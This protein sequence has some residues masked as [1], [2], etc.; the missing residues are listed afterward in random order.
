[1]HIMAAAGPSTALKVLALAAAL[2]LGPA[3]QAADDWIES[4][5]PDFVEA[6]EGLAKGRVQIESGYAVERNKQGDER[7]RTSSTPLMLRYGLSDRF[8]LRMETEG[9][10]RQRT[11]TFE[12]PATTRAR[13]MADS[14]IGILWHVQDGE[15]GRASVGVLF[16]A[17]LPSGARAFRGRGVRPSLRVSAE[18]DLGGGNTLGIMPGVQS[19]TGEDGKRF[20]S[21]LFGV[22]LG[23]DF[24]ERWHAFAELALPQ[25]ARIDDGGTQLTFDTGVSYRVSQRCA[26]DAGVFRGLNRRSADLQWTVGLS[27]RL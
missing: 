23:H 17:D 1:M 7:Q 3:A 9:W 12:P 24:N 5:R 8:E 21:A 10:M 6:S 22:N 15:A 19:D 20:T 13:G 18:W 2:A 11:D 16:D 14:T 25:I 26:I 4:D 27:Y